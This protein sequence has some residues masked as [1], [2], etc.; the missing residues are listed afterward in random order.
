MLSSW[1]KTQA[2]FFLCA[3]FLTDFETVAEANAILYIAVISFYSI[4][5]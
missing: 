3:G 4:D 5:N 1:K 2:H